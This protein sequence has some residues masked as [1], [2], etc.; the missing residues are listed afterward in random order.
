MIRAQLDGFNFYMQDAINAFQIV[1]DQNQAD[2]AYFRATGQVATRNETSALS[3]PSASPTSAS[4]GRATVPPRELRSEDDELRNEDDGFMDSFNGTEAA[5][6]N[7]NRD[8]Q[9]VRFEWNPYHVLLIPSIYFFRY[10]GS[11]TEPPCAEMVSWFV[12]DKP[13]IVSFEQLQQLRNIQFTHV[14]A[15]CHLTSVDFEGSVARP[16]QPTNDRTVWRCTEENF[17]ADPR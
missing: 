17:L 4:L 15:T 2:C 13:M 6:D 7:W 3:T 12:S 16:I 11:I 14:D 1:Y 9:E 8:L 5:N 10:D